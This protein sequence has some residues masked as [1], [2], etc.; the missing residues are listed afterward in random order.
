MFAQA[1]GTLDPLPESDRGR[2]LGIVVNRFAS[3]YTGQNL[4]GG[5]GPE[6]ATVSTGESR[7]ENDRWRLVV[8]ICGANNFK[9]TERTHGVAKSCLSQ[10]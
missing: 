1:P 9:E 6:F 10:A 7:T 4:C 2:L 8:G 5:V 3:R